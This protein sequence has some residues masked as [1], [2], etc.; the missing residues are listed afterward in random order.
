MIQDVG[1]DHFV[2][3][4]FDFF[5]SE[6]KKAEMNPFF[7][8]LSISSISSSSSVDQGGMRGMGKMCSFYFCCIFPGGKPSISYFISLNE[9]IWWGDSGGLLRHITFAKSGHDS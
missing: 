2:G 3:K 7:L 6:K 9:T 4:L 8:T 1:D 5:N